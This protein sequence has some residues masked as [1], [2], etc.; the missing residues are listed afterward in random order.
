MDAAFHEMHN[1]C[2]KHPKDWRWYT[3]W[4]IILHSDETYIGSLCFKG[5]PANGSVEI[6]YGID[7]PYQNQGYATDAVKAAAEWAFFCEGVYF[8]IAETERD[9][10]ASIRVLKKNGFEL[11][12]EGEEGLRWKKEKPKMV[13]MPI[14]MCL[15]MSCGLAISTAS[16][17]TGTG[18]SFGLCLGL[19]IGA[20]MDARNKS[21]RDKYKKELK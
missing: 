10:Q 5:G 9:N 1:G 4:Q 6:G 2:A 20:A 18:L 17:N 8:V 21:L 12:G 7:E 14:Y 3:N 15:G 16:G 13:W 19:A 11:F